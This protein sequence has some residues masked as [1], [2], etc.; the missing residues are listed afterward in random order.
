METINYS[1]PENQVDCGYCKEEKICKIRNPKVNTAK[2]GC[3]HFK[4]Y[5]KEL[6]ELLVFNSE[7]EKMELQQGLNKLKK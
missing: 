4:H 1:K 6:E 5:M 2:L 7:E 3:K